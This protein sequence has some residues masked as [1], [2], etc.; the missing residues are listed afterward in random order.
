MTKQ[1]IRSFG[2]GLVASA[3]AL[4][5]FNANNKPAELTTEEMI[6]VL[7]EQNYIVQPAEQLESIVPPEGS[8]EVAEM[9]DTNK[10]QS[11]SA[12]IPFTIKPGTPSNEV[13]I[14]LKKAGLI[15]D[16]IAFNTYLKKHGY[17]NKI[18]AGTYSFKKGI[19]MEE[20]A[21]SLLP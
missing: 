9:S 3:A 17:A 19:S 6:K 12:S 15:E 11:K 21:L 7:S 2:F 1:S 18:Q 10:N 8:K 16:E 4:F 13:A 20:L 5:L 14:E